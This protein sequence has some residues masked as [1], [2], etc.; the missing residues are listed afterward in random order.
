MQSQLQAADAPMRIPH[1]TASDT[2]KDEAAHGFWRDAFE[3]APVVAAAARMQ[4]STDEDDDIDDG[5]SNHGAD[6]YMQ[7]SDS[8]E[9]IHPPVSSNKSVLW[10]RPP[11]TVSS[12]EEEEEEEESDS[13]ISQPVQMPTLEAV[14][15]I[16]APSPPRR[17]KSPVPEIKPEPD[18][19]DERDLVLISHKRVLPAA[20]KRHLP[21]MLSRKQRKIFTAM[22]PAA[23]AA[24]KAAGLQY[25]SGRA[26]VGSATEELGDHEFE[27]RQNG[28]RATVVAAQERQD[29][30]Q[31]A[32]DLK[33]LE[34]HEAN[35]QRAKT[36]RKNAPFDIDAFNAL[37]F[38]KP[39]SFSLNL[40]TTIE[41]YVLMRK[42]DGNRA[43]WDG[44]RLYSKKGKIV[45]LPSEWAD[46]MPKGV[47]LDGELHRNSTDA[48]AKKY[49]TDLYNVSTVWTHKAF[50]DIQKE[51]RF[52]SGLKFLAFDILDPAVLKKPLSKRLVELDKLVPKRNDVFSVSKHV[53]FKSAPYRNKHDFAL[54][55]EKECKRQKVIL[56]DAGGAEGLLLK[57]SSSP[58]VGTEG[59]TRK[60]L[61]YK[62]Y[63]DIE[64][65][66]MSVPKM[67]KESRYY[68]MVQLPR[69]G[70]HVVVNTANGHLLEG[71]RLQPGMIVNLEYMLGTDLREPVIRNILEE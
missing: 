1:R 63:G 27:M 61:K 50:F 21:E 43:K 23:A 20:E 40:I 33:V 54:A 59:Y 7:S 9:A 60:W 56:G 25:T 64:A 8:S 45:I 29:A 11:P 39:A 57:R 67:N 4:S 52:W 37:L 15:R 42:V 14:R 6:E 16:S 18:K 24:S 35:V 44:N 48:A 31:R 53:T 30:L 49:K 17:P 51:N 32:A 12:E 68:V 55:L 38:M 70:E 65:R 36:A 5:L 28:K 13:E 69:G 46:K 41:D 3:T 66:V 47:L 34:A 71:D 2:S 62:F 10:L 22:S 19:V 26:A 58:Y